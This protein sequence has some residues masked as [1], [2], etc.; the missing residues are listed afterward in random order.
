MACGCGQG[1]KIGVIGTWPADVRALK[2]RIDPSMVS[3]D[4]SVKACPGLSSLDR[5]AWTVFYAS[6]KVF[7]AA[8]EPLLFG[9]GVQY[10]EA[11]GFAAQL[12]RIRADLRAKNCAVAAGGDLPAPP[13]DPL[14][15]I[16]SVVKWTAAA[17]IV[18]SVVWGVKSFVK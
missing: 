10:D 13:T 7:H 16:P 8:P 5:S 4:E 17:V 2:D 12:E 1:Q 14:S 6:W 11:L 9:S 3:T 15:E 18:A